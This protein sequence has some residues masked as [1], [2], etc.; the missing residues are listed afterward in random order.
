MKVSIGGQAVS[1]GGVPIALP[2][3]RVTVS[4][5]TLMRNGAA[6]RAWGLQVQ[7]L[8]I[9]HEYFA[10]GDTEHRA[11]MATFFRGIRGMGANT[12]RIHLNLWD[13]IEGADEINL[14][15][16]SGSV[17]NLLYLLDVARENAI[18]VL[19]NGANTW[20]PD[21]VPAWYDALPYATRWDVQAFFWSEI[22]A[23]V[24][25]AGHSTTVLG[26]DLINEPYTSADPAAD[27]Y[28]TMLGPYAFTHLI[29]RGPA[30][31][32]DTVRDW[33]TQQRDA[34]KAQDPRALVTYG[35]LG[36]GYVGPMGYENTQDLLDFLCPHIYPSLA[37]FGLTPEEVM[38][39]VAGWTGATVPLVI[40]ETML[41]SD[42][43]HTADYMEAVTAD[44]VGIIAGSYGYPPYQYTVPPETPRYPAPADGDPSFYAVFAT[45]LLVFN[46]YRADFLAP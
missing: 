13:C 23:A 22:A 42:A 44:Y 38:A 30:V 20:L 28:G 6:F 12:T 19:I 14:T 46:G 5:S 8:D 16:K 41:W 31:D 18:Y 26:Y 3:P 7:M 1:I 4:G 29:A 21:D 35:A 15:V 27:W 45:S 37:F 36:L 9:E 17:A 40:G 32:D 11:T 34:I 43:D 39:E 10:N 33:I 2:M 25:A 24:Y